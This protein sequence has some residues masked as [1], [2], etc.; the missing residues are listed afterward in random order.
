[1]AEHDASPVVPSNAGYEF[2]QDWFSGFIPIWKELLA[3]VKPSKILEIGSFEGRSTC[4]LIETSGAVKDLEVHCV[5]T[6]EGGVEHGEIDMPAVERRFSKNTSLAI[7]FAAHRVN[8][9]VHKKPSHLALTGLLSSGHASSFDL[10]YVD[11]S[12]QAP[13]VLSDAVLSF[14]LLRTEGLLIF[15][16]YLLTQAPP[17]KEDPFNMP[18]PAIDGFVNIY[19][20]K[21]RILS[22]HLYQIYTQK[23]SE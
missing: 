8:L 21:L 17:G 4:Y 2:T 14:H 10:I 19:Q 20:R 18:K 5:D 11:G 7:E 12:H 23:I 1:M 22:A 9:I 16:D 15:D 6:W 13:D 3:Q